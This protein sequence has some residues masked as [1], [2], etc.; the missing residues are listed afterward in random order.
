M[1]FLIGTVGLALLK[2]EFERDTEYCASQFFL[3][4]WGV[5]S[6]VMLILV[7]VLLTTVLVIIAI[8]HDFHIVIPLT[9]LLAVLYAASFT[10][11]LWR[12]SGMSVLFRRSEWVDA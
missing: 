3:T 5:L 4:H 7:E 10:I 9:L 2:K 11:P 1:L 12:V 6:F 8:L